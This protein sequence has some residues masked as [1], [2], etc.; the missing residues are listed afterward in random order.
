M[1]DKIDSVKLSAYIITHINTYSSCY[2][3]F[4]VNRIMQSTEKLKVKLKESHINAVR[5][6]LQH[7]RAE[8]KNPQQ[9]AG[10]GSDVVKVALSSF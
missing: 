5:R 9:E 1:V 3:L 8:L 10:R 7:S 6:N 2:F 4:R